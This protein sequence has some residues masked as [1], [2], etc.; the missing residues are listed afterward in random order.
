MMEALSRKTEKEKLVELEEMLADATTLTDD[1]SSV[2]F[3]SELHTPMKYQ[4]ETPS[5]RQDAV[6]PVAVGR[7]NGNRTHSS[8]IDKSFSREADVTAKIFSS[9]STADSSVEE[10]AT[11]RHQQELHQR[12]A[13]RHHRRSDRDRQRT[14]PTHADDKMAATVALLKSELQATRSQVEQKE[15]VAR[16][17]QRQLDQRGEIEAQTQAR[18]EEDLVAALAKASGLKEELARTSQ[19]LVEGALA[20]QHLEQRCATLTQN[21]HKS[22]TR[23][24]ELEEEVSVSRAELV[25]ISGVLHARRGT[26][27]VDAERVFGEELQRVQESATLEARA[28]RQEASNLRTSLEQT[29]T[30][31]RKSCEERDS[32]REEA[33]ALS[34][35]AGTLRET[36]HALRLYSENDTIDQLLGQVSRWK[37]R[38]EE[39]ED[40][41]RVASSPGGFAFGSSNSETEASQCTESNEPSASPK[42]SGLKPAA[43]HPVMKTPERRNQQERRDVEEAGRDVE[44]NSLRQELSA[45]QETL[46][47][48]EE[49]LATVVLVAREQGVQRAAA[50]GRVKSLQREAEAAARAAR[51]DVAARRAAKARDMAKLKNVIRHDM[52]N[53]LCR[54]QREVREQKQEQKSHTTDGAAPCKC[55]HERSS[56][57]LGEDK[58][59][60]A[61]GAITPSAEDGGL[62]DHED[63]LTR[64][65]T[66]CSTCGDESVGSITDVTNLVS[67]PAATDALEEETQKGI[68]AATASAATQMFHAALVSL[69]DEATGGPGEDDGRHGF[70]VPLLAGLEVSGSNDAS[71]SAVVPWVPGEAKIDAAQAVQALRGT[72][73]S[74][75]KTVPP[76]SR[77]SATGSQTVPD[78]PAAVVP[79]V[80]RNTTGSQTD[81]EP[82]RNALGARQHHVGVQTGGGPNRGNAETLSGGGGAPAW[83]GDID[84]RCLEGGRV[85][86]DGEERVKQADGRM[87][88]LERTADALSQALQRAKMEKEGQQL[89]LVTR[90]EQEKAA[91]LKQQRDVFEADIAEL[92][93]AMMATVHDFSCGNDGVRVAKQALVRI[94]GCT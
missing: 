24:A 63:A 91:L 17:L 73:Q 77:V 57:P 44:T 71:S 41:Q 6:T 74:A 15:V 64:A 76:D 54:L 94:T 25:R 50:E 52:V 43:L 87:A 42:A 45:A 10:V 5:P 14:R 39:L 36:V 90:F 3:G 12:A 26:D 4:H 93:S 92:Y 48:M 22:V 55:Q 37:C 2:S 86:D 75:Q 18:S 7:T 79:A 46:A 59:C 66:C 78:P 29:K 47:M 58:A 62:M 81:T 35:E 49:E 31:L 72:I 53:E 89:M 27:V 33:E 28:L 70:E 8:T 1:A 68:A 21:L 56:Q 60:Q 16:S 88:E 11:R 69:C 23:T 19:L 9:S 34:S 30:K 85:D 83:E 13:R 40:L 84:W 51:E 32:W 82:E 61:N 67:H 65:C 80:S 20:R 38:A